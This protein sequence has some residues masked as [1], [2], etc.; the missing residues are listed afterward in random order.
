MLA[1]LIYSV[2]SLL[3]V[4]GASTSSEPKGKGKTSTPCA[5]THTVQPQL[6][7]LSGLSDARERDALPC[8]N[9]VKTKAD[10][11]AYD[12]ERV[13]LIGIYRQYELKKGPQAGGKRKHFRGHVY[14]ELQDGE[15]VI[16]LPVWDKNSIRDRK[17]I[18]CYKGKRVRLIGVIHKVAPNRPDPIPAQNL[19]VPCLT[20]LE[21]IELAPEG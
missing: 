8:E 17:E 14:I 16:L 18:K 10:I 1:Q 9:E 2:I 20:D 15:G 4:L 3:L 11:D 19:M 7:G 21:S 6:P 5:N 12:Q 13:H